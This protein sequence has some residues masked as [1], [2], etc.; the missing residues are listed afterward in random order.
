MSEFPDKIDSKFR[1]VLLSAHRA[2]QLMRGAPP[3]DGEEG[4]PTVV[5]MDEV[6]SDAVEWSYGQLDGA[7]LETATVAGINSST[8]EEDSESPPES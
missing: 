5:A 3:K 6:A 2:E 7:P 4:K 1:Y 8:T